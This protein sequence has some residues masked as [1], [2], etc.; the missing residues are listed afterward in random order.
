MEY[1]TIRYLYVVRA[2]LEKKLVLTAK[3]FHDKVTFE[4]LKVN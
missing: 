2:I 3:C 1:R 4:I